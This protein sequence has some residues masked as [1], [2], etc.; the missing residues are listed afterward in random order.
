MMPAPKNR[1]CKSVVFLATAAP[2]PYLGEGSY[3]RPHCAFIVRVMG[4]VRSASSAERPARLIHDF[5]V[6]KEVEDDMARDGE[7]PVS[8]DMKQM[9]LAR[10]GVPPLGEES[11][12]V[13]GEE[14]FFWGHTT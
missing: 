1:F 9:L 5:K 3:H 6:I 7:P 12:I 14:D 13:I 4:A 2:N 8:E 11:V 10:W